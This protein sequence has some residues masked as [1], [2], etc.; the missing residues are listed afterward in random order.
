MKK[1]AERVAYLASLIALLTV[2]TLG[3][4]NRVSVLMNTAQA[5][6]MEIENGGK[7]CPEANTTTCSYYGCD[8]NCNAG[9]C[10]PRCMG[11]GTGCADTLCT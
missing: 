9:G 2:I 1:L 11:R 7:T 6:D 10:N 3:V 5:Q 4:S 8:S